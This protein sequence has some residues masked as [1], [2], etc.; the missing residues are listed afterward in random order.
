M[1]ERPVRQDEHM[2]AIIGNRIGSGRINDD[3]TVM[4]KL[5]LKPAVAVIPIGSRLL[6][7]EFIGKAGAGPD[8]GETNARHTVHL[9]WDNEAVPVNRGVLIFQSVVDRE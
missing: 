8:A 2:F 7:G 4:A 3:R 6:D 5:L 9:E 1:H